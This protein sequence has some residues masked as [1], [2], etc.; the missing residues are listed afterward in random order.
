[1]V[2]PVV[3][4]AALQ[5]VVQLAGPVGGQHHDRRRRRPHGAELGDRDLV[6]REHLEQ[7]RL[8]LVVGPVHLVDQQHGRALLQRAQ[9]GPRQQEPLV[10]QALLGLLDAPRRAAGDR[11]HRPQV[12]DLAREVPV[13]ERL[14]GVDALVALQPHQRQ[15]QGLGDRLGEGGLAGAGLALEEQRPLHR[16]GEVGDGG[17]RVVAQV[18]RRAEA[19]LDLGHGVHALRLRRGALAGGWSAHPAPGTLGHDRSRPRPPA[20]TSGSSGPSSTCWRSAPTAR[21]SARPR[22]R[23]WSAVRTVGTDGWRDLM[24][25]ARQAAAG[26]WRPARSRSPRAARWSTRHAARGPIRIRRTLLTGS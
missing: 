1:M 10:V 21:R 8:E 4:A 5:R 22:R 19:L 13:V 6:G 16:Q 7:E 17:Q 15:V 3:E 24:D 12:Q 20:P 26:S 9:D 2:D 14:R 11:L 25:P 18:A 23:G